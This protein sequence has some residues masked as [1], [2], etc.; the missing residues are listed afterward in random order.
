MRA[1]GSSAIASSESTKHGILRSGTEKAQAERLRLVREWTYPVS[2]IPDSHWGGNRNELHTFW[3][4]SLAGMI[5][6]ATIGLRNGPAAVNYRGTSVKFAKIDSGGSLCHLFIFV[7]MTLSLLFAD[8]RSVVIPHDDALLPHWSELAAAIE[9]FDG[10]DLE[11][12]IGGVDLRQ[13]VVSLLAPT[14]AS[15][16]K[17]VSLRNTSAREIG[18]ALNF[19][20]EILRSNQ[21]LDD[22]CYENVLENQRASELL[23]KCIMAHPELSSVKVN[24]CYNSNIHGENA[25]FGYGMLR[26][27]LGM[28]LRHLELEKNNINT[29]GCTFL[30]DY[31]ASNTSLEYLG[32]EGNHL[33]DDDLRR[34][35]VAL[36][37]N[38]RLRSLELK[39]NK[40]TTTGIGWLELAVLG[41]RRS[42]SIA[43]TTLNSSVDC[44]HTCRI[45]YIDYEL[46]TL[47]DNQSPLKNKLLKLYYTLEQMTLEGVLVKKLSTIACENLALLMPH[48]LGRVETVHL[49][50]PRD[51]R[52]LSDDYAPMYRPLT[53]RFDLLR[54]TPGI[55]EH[56]GSAFAMGWTV[57]SRSPHLL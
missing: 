48:I 18:T 51:G 8:I 49:E 42:Q 28:N 21:H 37:S 16:C 38:N 12:D 44:N 22:F 43:D 7:Q 33:N 32:L 15:R 25:T 1:L 9:N 3:M 29:D 2:D 27:L 53:I 23:C 13:S 6:R 39:W 36:M 17:S 31:I 26:N 40:Y 14:L 47:N 34:I 50:L 55:F 24:R 10:D 54:R 11:F 19:A 30:S 56:G 57:N 45:P 35:G 52:P 4:G 20:I 46:D 5:K 41:R